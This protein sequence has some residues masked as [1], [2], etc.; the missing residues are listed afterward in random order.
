MRHL[1]D[2]EGA[3]IT[4]RVNVSFRSGILFT[5]LSTHREGKKHFRYAGWLMAYYL[6]ANGTTI[7][8]LSGVAYSCPK[9]ARLSGFWFQRTVIIVRL[10]DHAS[11]RP[12][13][14]SPLGVLFS[15]L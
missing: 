2:T 15:F 6:N 13:V 7:A 4:P 5:V 9:V 14:V 12:K 8:R 11:I 10:F 1:P 3:R